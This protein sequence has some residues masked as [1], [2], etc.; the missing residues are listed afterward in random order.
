MP[1]PLSNVFKDKMG[2]WRTASL[3]EETITPDVRVSYDP[4][5]LLRED[6]DRD[7]LVSMK[8]IYMEAND[9]TEYAA[10]KRIFGSWEPWEHL[11]NAPFFKEEVDKWRKQLS[12]KLQSEATAKIIESATEGGKLSGTQ[13]QSAKWVAEG[14]WVRKVPS[15]DT[16]GDSVPRNVG[17][18]SKESV[19]R[20]AERLLRE[21]LNTRSAL[22]EDAR[23]A[24]IVLGEE[25]PTSH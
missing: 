14:G 1:S 24:G 20:E 17:R 10:A 8:R 12:L 5:F 22:E 13:F 19:T 25:A 15:N 9:P 23:R 21:G 4:I 11:C 16:G 6:E 18:P 3:F 2:R 7:G